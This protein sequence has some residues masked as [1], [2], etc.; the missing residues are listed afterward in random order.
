MRVGRRNP[1]AIKLRG[2]QRQLVTLTRRALL[3]RALHVEPFAVAPGARERAV[4]VD[5]DAEIGALGRER[6]GWDHVVHQ[7]LDEG[8]LIEIEEFIAGPFRR[9]GT[10]SGRRRL[11]LRG[12]RR[13][14]GGCR[15]R[16]C[17]ATDDGAFEKNLDD[18]IL[19]LSWAPPCHWVPVTRAPR[20]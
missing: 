8:R 17:G 5:V 16:R 3:P 15:A 9:G 13:S 6:V 12:F 1:G 4:D 2:R 19:V 10:S 18:R 7:R 11:S 14:D 20:T